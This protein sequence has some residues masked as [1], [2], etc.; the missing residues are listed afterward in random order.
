[1]RAE[2]RDIVKHTG[3]LGFVETVKITGSDTE[4]VIETVAT[5]NTVIVK[6]KLNNPLGEFRGVFGLSN[7]GLLRN[8]VEFPTYKTDG[9]AVTVKRRDRNGDMIPE[10]IVFKDENGSKDCYRLMAQEVIPDQPRFVGVSW[11]VEIAPS[12]ST[13]K[14]F[15]QRAAMY[16][17]LESLFGVDIV[18]GDLVFLFGDKDGSTHRGTMV[19]EKGIGGSMKGE[20][21]WP[22]SPVLQIL[23]LSDGSDCT[24]SISQKGAL[25]I[26]IE[27][28]VGEYRYILPA[29]KNRQ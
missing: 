3:S 18:D 4:T 2:I 9:A 19:F 29:K 20:Q 21:W 17:S 24:M 27:T 25:Q 14:E 28:P 1:M 16:G 6:G 13:L 8:L 10:E 11:D 15:M 12:K 23:K 5:D 26:T 22:M 7:L